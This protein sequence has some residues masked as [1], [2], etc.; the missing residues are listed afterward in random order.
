MEAH[1][2]ELLGKIEAYEVTIEGARR[3]PAFDGFM[4]QEYVNEMKEIHAFFKDDVVPKLL[5]KLEKAI[6][7]NEKDRKGD[8]G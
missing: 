4:H 5:Q 6:L 7:E 8:L 3:S 2:Q 1:R